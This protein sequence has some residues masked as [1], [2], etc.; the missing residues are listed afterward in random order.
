MGVIL[1]YVYGRAGLGCEFS[2]VMLFDYS[3]VVVVQLMLMVPTLV[4]TQQVLLRER[5]Q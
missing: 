1:Y 2:A 4:L 3:V 5:L